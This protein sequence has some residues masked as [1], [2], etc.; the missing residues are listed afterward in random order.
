[1]LLS[2][3]LWLLE[4]N[5][6]V[7]SSLFRDIDTILAIAKGRPSPPPPSGCGRLRTHIPLRWKWVT[8]DEAAEVAEEAGEPQPRGLEA[9]ASRQ[10]SRPRLARQRPQ[11]TKFAGSYGAA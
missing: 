7:A 8:I 6:I 3:G 4:G 11:G 5:D 10:A 1:V 9:S 2:D